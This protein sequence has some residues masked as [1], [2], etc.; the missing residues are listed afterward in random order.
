[1]IG[2]S[3]NDTINGGAGNDS[4]I[5]AAGNDSLAG[6]VDN[7]TLS[8]GLGNDVLNGA[9]GIDTATYGGETDAMFVDLAAGT[10]RRGSSPDIEDT[11]SAIENIIGGAGNDTLSGN[12]SANSLDG[13]AGDDAILG[14]GGSDVLSGG[15]G[16]DA[17]TGGA[18]SDTL[19]GGAGNDTFF[20]TIGDGADA[21]DG[22]ADADALAIAG[23][24]SND[25]LDVVFSGTALATVEGGTLANV[26][27]VRADLGAG[28]DTLNYAGTTVGVAANLATGAAS[29]FGGAGSLVGIENVIGG[30]GNDT[31]VGTSGANTLTGGLGNDTLD[32]NG[33]ADSL[34][35]GAGD[36]TYVTDGGGTLTEAT[37]AGIDIVQSSAATFTLGNNFENLTLTG[38]ANINGTGNG[39]NNLITGN[40]GNNTLA[41]AAGVDTLVG[42]NGDDTLVG[43]TGNDVMTG[44]I[45][46]DTFVFNAFNESG[47]GAGN[48]DQITDFV[49]AGIVGGDTI[50][51]SA[52][53]AIAGGSDQAFT[54]I[55]S[56]AFTAAG[57]LRVVQQGGDAIVQANSNGNTSNIEFEL[58]LL[59]THNLTSGDFIL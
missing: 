28:N 25:T 58:R 13:G 26:E 50:D 16:N 22:G 53:D 52:L 46:N 18:A 44:G 39:L 20:Y 36:D 33:G 6:G 2:S 51:L 59:G 9:G 32:G 48:N 7:D 45:G 19:S 8:G 3:S 30:S 29:G 23:S 40:D 41:G 55:G 43:G 37:N 57:Q 56:A 27:S 49:G 4:L 17:L 42:G 31:L 5:G 38:F 34:A 24:A 21:V 35:G 14:G 1:L 11:L 47:I 10:A 12:G 15:D 54:F